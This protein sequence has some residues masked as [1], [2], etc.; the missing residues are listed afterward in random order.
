MTLQVFKLG[1]TTLHFSNQIDTA[2]FYS[3]I[4]AFLVVLDP[5]TASTY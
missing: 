2:G 4:N 5:L 3:W 1:P